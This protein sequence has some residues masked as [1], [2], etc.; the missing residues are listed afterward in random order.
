MVLALEQALWG[1]SCRWYMTR[2]VSPAAAVAAVPCSVLAAWETQS[3]PDGTPC[4]HSM[5]AMAV[6]STLALWAV[7]G[8]WVLP[9]SN[10]NPIDRYWSRA[11][12]DSSV[13]RRLLRREE[14]SGRTD[15]F[16]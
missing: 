6:A 15:T 4:V 1:G 14:G 16:A 9:M 8:A 5:L 7:A 10:P 12:F 2:A 3:A 11:V 13:S